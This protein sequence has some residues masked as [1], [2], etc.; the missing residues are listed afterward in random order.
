M[1]GDLL[2]RRGARI[3]ARNLSVDGGELDLVAEIGGEWVAVEVRSRTGYDALDAF[4]ITKADQVW[5]LAR[6]A[7]CVRVDLVAVTF[8]PDRV[9]LRWVP[10]IG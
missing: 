7:G 3:L 4:G 10:G 5:R 1:A 8:F 2:R 6:S 9:D